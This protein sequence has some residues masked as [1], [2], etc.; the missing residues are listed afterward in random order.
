MVQT[1]QI[2][3]TGIRNEFWRRMILAGVRNPPRYVQFIISEGVRAHPQGTKAMGYLLTCPAQ[4]DRDINPLGDCN[5][6]RVIWASEIFYL[7][8]ECFAADGQLQRPSEDPS[9][10]QKTTRVFT[11]MLASEY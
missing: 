6:L 4:M 11:C 3:P 5:L 7:K 1:V 2:S 8:V 9:D 10:D